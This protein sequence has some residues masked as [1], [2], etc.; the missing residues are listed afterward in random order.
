LGRAG[1]HPLRRD[2]RAH[3]RRA[4]RESGSVFE[5]VLPLTRSEVD[6]CERADW[7]ELEKA[8]EEVI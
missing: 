8:A 3:P 1:R 5:A 2:A 4:R 6:D 7:S